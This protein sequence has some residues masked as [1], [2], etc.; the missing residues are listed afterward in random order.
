MSIGCPKVFAERCYEV[1]RDL[2]KEEAIDYLA[3]VIEYRERVLVEPSAKRFYTALNIRGHDEWWTDG[4]RQDVEEEAWQQWD[5]NGRPDDDPPM[6]NEYALVA[7]HKV[8][9]G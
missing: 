1:M 2:G 4:T 3:S 7:T 8:K 9:D 6:I 5:D